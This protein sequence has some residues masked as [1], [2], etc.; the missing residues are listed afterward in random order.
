MALIKCPE[1][2]KEI[3]DKASACPNCGCPSSEW[4]KSNK[5]DDGGADVESERCLYCGS[6]NIGED[7]YCENC[8]MKLDPSYQQGHAITAK[9]TDK[10]TFDESKTRKTSRC[11]RCGSQ[12]PE[13][14]DVCPHCGY[15][16]ITQ[17]QRSQVSSREQKANKK[18]LSVPKIIL[19]IVVALICL[20]IIAQ[21]MGD[22]ALVLFGILL[23]VC[24][25]C[26]LVSIIYLI[27]CIFLK[28]N[29]TPAYTMIIG[30]A[31]LFVVFMFMS[32]QFVPDADKNSAESTVQ[33]DAEEESVEYIDGFEKAEYE[34]F[35]SYACENGLDGSLIYIEGK[36]LSQTKLDDKDSDIP[37]LVLIIE[38]E[39]ENRWCAAVHSDAELNSIEDEEVRIFGTYVGFSDVF[40]LPSIDVATTNEEN[41]DKARID[42]LNDSGDYETIWKFSD[43]A[44]QVASENTEIGAEETT[45]EEQAKESEEIN[46]ESLPEETVID[47]SP[48]EALLNDLYSILSKEVADK[49]YDIL[50]NQIGFTNVTY[51]G[52]NSVGNTNY[53]FTSDE[54]DFTITA[55]DDVYRVFQPNGGK[56]FYESGE[57]KYTAVDMKSRTIDH[58]NMFSYYMIAQEIVESALKNPRSADFPSIVTHPEEVAMSKKDDIIGVQSYVDAQNSFGGTVR[59]EWVVEFRVID[60]SA[61][62]Y[63]PLYV[64]IDGEVLYGEYIDLD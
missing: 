15:S 64:N 45:T 63:E 5:S 62:S 39:S 52:K 2:G 11:V 18:R 4:S 58:D 44:N 35:N 46:K 25:I 31:A 24:M 26:F 23:F 32:F 19:I 12:I 29:K 54:C 10:N 7:G 56:T 27:V 53:D 20:E 6:E 1:C 8:G 36:V 59:S 42:V 60:L 30:S 34:K 16:Y 28:K 51:I 57:V 47:I 38:Q 43:Y 3:S 33:V 13:G 9:T 40:N 55:S 50:V 48:S 61:Y 37:I 22:A 41:Y 49:T 14:I 17:S 21:I